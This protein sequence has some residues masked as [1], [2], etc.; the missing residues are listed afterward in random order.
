MYEYRL[1]RR[2]KIVITALIIILFSLTDTLSKGMIARAQ[3]NFMDKLTI[4]TGSEVLGFIKT[5]F[6]KEKSD[7]ICADSNIDMEN[8]SSEKSYESRGN[9]K[10][11]SETFSSAENKKNDI[12]SVEAEQAFIYKGKKIAFLTFDDGPSNNITPQ[13]LDILQKY[14]VKATFFVIGSL[15]KSNSTVLKDIVNRGHVIGIH[16][17]T[18]K[19]KVIY[20]SAENFTNEIRMTEAV[21]KQTLGKEFH[22]RLFRFPGGSFEGY[23]KQYKD[24]LKKNGYVSIDWN[25][26]TGDAETTGLPPQK[27]LDRLKA[28][29]KGKLQLVVLMHDSS[30]KQT[31]VDALPGII[32][33]LKSQG[34]EFGVLN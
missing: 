24:I 11:L 1:T 31:T 10:V 13:V 34:Y 19:Y 2:G 27:L 18:H 29:S 20:K 6:Y 8:R 23:K 14:D 21:F 33:Y 30:D 28:T 25:V 4:S 16:T 15:S 26:V 5:D 12:L 9:S 17:Y 3:N 32:E 22:T 7:E